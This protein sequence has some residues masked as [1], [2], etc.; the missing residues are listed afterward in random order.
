MLR[1]HAL[2]DAYRFSPLLNSSLDHLCFVMN[3]S[4]L[5]TPVRYG[6]SFSEMAVARGGSTEKGDSPEDFL[7]PPNGYFRLTLTSANPNE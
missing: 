4:T 5:K 2:V 1:G 6:K 7:R 3:V